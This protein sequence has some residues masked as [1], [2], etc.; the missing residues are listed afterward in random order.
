MSRGVSETQFR[1]YGSHLQLAAV[2]TI[3]A[4]RFRSPVIENRRVAPVLVQIA[5][6]SVAETPLGLNSPLD[7]LEMTKSGVRVES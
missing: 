7:F 6:V 1:V 2:I 5:T 4:L 3:T